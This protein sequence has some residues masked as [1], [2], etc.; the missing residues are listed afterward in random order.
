M[1]GGKEGGR[2]MRE[3]MIARHGSEE[4]WRESMRKLGSEGGRKGAEVR[5]KSDYPFAKDRVLAK[6]ASDIAASN[7]HKEE[8]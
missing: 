5:P 8:K 1:S 4:A 3:T 2:K 7:R 6:R